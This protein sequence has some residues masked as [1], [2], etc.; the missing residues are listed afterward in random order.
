M[1]SSFVD[2]GSEI[3]LPP[4]SD[5]GGDDDDDD[6]DDSDSDEDRIEKEKT[7]KRT[8]DGS[9]RLATRVRVVRA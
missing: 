4:P 1:L 7:E 2:D 5:G 9:M 8:L 6:D 3:P